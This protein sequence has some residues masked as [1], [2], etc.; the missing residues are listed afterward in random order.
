MARLLQLILAAVM[1]IILFPV[2]VAAHAG[3]LRADPAPGTVLAAPPPQIVLEFTERLDPAVSRL[4][5]LDDQGRLLAET[6]AVD[7]AQPM[8]MHLEPGALPRGSYTVAWR[9]RSTEDGH[10]TVGVVPFGIGVAAD[11][12]LMLP[13]PGAPAPALAPPPPAGV[14]GRWLALVG[15]GLAV[16]AIGF[17]LLIWRR[18]WRTRLATSMPAASD[19][20]M[21]DTAMGVSLGR[22]IRV[23]A[24]LVCLGASV[25]G[26]DHLFNTRD[27]STTVVAAILTFPTGPAGFAAVSRAVVAVI[28]AARVRTLAAP[29][30][31]S[32]QPWRAALAIGILLL[33]TFAASGHRA[34][35]G[36][37]A[38]LLMLLSV[39]HLTAMALWLGGLPGL[40]IAVRRAA[41][42][43]RQ[44][45]ATAV[46]NAG[47]LAERPALPILVECFSTVAAIS[48]A[49][50]TISG[51]AAAVVHV[52]SPELL[53]TTTYGRALLVKAAV[54][55]ALLGLGA[56]HM[57]VVGPRLRP[58]GP[59]A[60]H[61]CLTLSMELALALVVLAAAATQ[62]TTAPSRVAWAAQEQVGQRAAVYAH[63]AHLVLWVTPGQAGDNL[64]ALDVVDAQIGAGEPV[65]LFRASMPRH[66]MTPLEMTGTPVGGG[67][68]TVRGSFLTM[69]GGWEVEA[70]VRRPGLPDVRHTFGVNIDRRRK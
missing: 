5:L 18:A 61:F 6:S 16:G 31:G 57:L 56:L 1:A 30:G 23:G 44:T 27:G 21:I 41:P 40:L 59:W 68:Y 49:A 25:T 66:P 47:T 39:V 15:A 38:P 65:V 60:R 32:A 24:I 50:L 17:G 22:L 51:T 11:L 62:L 10:V 46:A 67:R 70:I 69:V 42:Q 63:G 26:L 19:P 28:L 12:A 14:L 2:P 55:L 48:V 43:R 35:T 20:S 29:G 53:A 3:L 45:P 9:A 54:L 37:P 52:D 58:G 64:L 4:Q 7:P 34:A 8:R 13:P 36:E 33:L